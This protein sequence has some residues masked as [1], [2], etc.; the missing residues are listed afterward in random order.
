MVLYRLD[1][2]QPAGLIVLAVLFLRRVLDP[3]YDP[4]EPPA[5]FPR[6]LLS[7]TPTRSWLRETRTTS[8]CSEQLCFFL[9]HELWLGLACL[10]L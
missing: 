5:L 6:Y 4:R 8:G 7:D 9:D 3:I 2:V 10:L 1:T